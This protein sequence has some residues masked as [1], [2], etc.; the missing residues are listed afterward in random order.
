MLTQNPDHGKLNVTTKKRRTSR[1]ISPRQSNQVLED[2]F[3]DVD[4]N[5]YGSSYTSFH[6]GE[7]PQNTLNEEA[8]EKF[9]KQLDPEDVDRGTYV[10]KYVMSITRN[11]T[12]ALTLSQIL[13]W[14]K[15]SGYDPRPDKK[16]FYKWNASSSKELGKQLYRTEDE[17]EKS[18]KRLKSS[19]L[20]DWKTKMFGG[21]RKRHIWII[22]EKIASEYQ[23]AR[24][25]EK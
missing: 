14:I 23:K 11:A 2:L 13:Y 10:P 20:I 6:K 16:L 9:L 25:E 3:E 1:I 15:L 19:G 22:W 4:D 24:N 12:D 7:T 5:K 17:I 21:S 8:R 18:L